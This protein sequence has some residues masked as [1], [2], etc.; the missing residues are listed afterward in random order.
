MSDRLDLITK[1][2]A[3]I[4]ALE[5][6]ILE[7]VERQRADEAVKSMVD[8]NRVVIETERVLKGHL[9]ALD[10]LAATYGAQGESL[11]KKAAV[12]ILGA[13]AGLYDK[14]RESEVT[15][16]IRDD[17]TALSLA[18]MGYTAMHAFGL[19]VNEPRIADLA[20]RHLKDLTPLLVELSKLIP[21]TTLQELAKEN[22]DMAV[23][24]DKV[25]EAVT[26]TQRAWERDVVNSLA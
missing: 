8:V 25:S 2:I 11:L 18:A 6:H 7:A 19:G 12:G 10:A 5:K 9:T 1:H 21:A 22:P 20:G 17:Y 3:D 24:T 26:N 15:R 16:A 4:S 14:L 23:A 13:A